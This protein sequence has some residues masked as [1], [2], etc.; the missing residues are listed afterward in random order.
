MRLAC[1]LPLLLCLPCACAAPPQPSAQA[2]RTTLAESRPAPKPPEPPSKSLPAATGE[3]RVSLV[4]TESLPPVLDDKT[5]PAGPS[6]KLDTPLS[7]KVVDLVGDQLDKALVKA[8]FKVIHSERA[9]WDLELQPRVEMVFHCDTSAW[10]LRTSV[11]AVTRQGELIA[12]FAAEGAVTPLVNDMVDSPRIVASAGTGRRTP[13]GAGPATTVSAP[14]PAV[15]AVAGDAQPKTWALIVGIER[16]REVVAATGA[17][18][19]AERFA[20]IAQRTLGVSPE[21]M[22]IA[23]DDRASHSDLEKHLAWL[24]AQVPEGGR[25]VFFY[26]GH[27]SPDGAS[28]TPYLLPYD[29][30]PSALPS[31]GFPLARAIKLLEQ[32][33]AREVIAL[34]DACF[35]GA[36]GRSVL[37]AGARPLVRVEQPAAPARIAVF[38][39][40]AGDQIAGASADGQQGL[41]SRYVAQGLSTGEADLDRDGK[42]SLEELR[43]WVTPRVVTE[44]RQANREQQPVLLLGA[45]LGDGKGLVLASGTTRN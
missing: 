33:R 11:R 26:S 44:A 34:V 41:F 7:P 1:R 17:R 31:T 30:D 37:P 28:G 10:K 21:H 45:G 6:P 3:I 24:K 19:D 40:A 12:S 14:P 20:Q 39:S 29:G 22:R 32:T 25:V 5:C 8:G 36:G 2:E 35:S 4:R 9:D 38:A 27:G 16:Y 15:A 43:S 18:A 13:A 23:L 42:I